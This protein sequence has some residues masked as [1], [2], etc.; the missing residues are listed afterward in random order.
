MVEGTGGT[1]MLGV[2]V[3][4]SE[5]TSLPVSVDWSTVDTVQPQPGVDFEAASGTLV[6]APGETSKVIPITVYADALDETGQL[7]GAEWGAVAFS[8]PVNATLEAGFGS[9]A[10]ALIV[11]DDPPPTVV[12][13]GC[14]VEG[15]EGTT[16]L[17]VPVTLSA[18]SGN[19]VT[20]DWA[21]GRRCSRRR[22]STSRRPRARSCSHRGRPPRPSRS[23]S[24]AT[25]S[26]N[27]ASSGAPSGAASGSP[28]RPTPSS[29]RDS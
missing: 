21:P 20:V 23:S 9:L 4:L 18:P 19:T 11:D 24:T 1:T 12:P 27:P 8:A 7:W 15:D 25:S 13:G 29:A 3:E 22:G 28:T 5:A 16:V 2:R 10:L 6:F 17:A 14:V 26:T